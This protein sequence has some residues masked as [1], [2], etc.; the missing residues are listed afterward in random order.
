MSDYKNVYLQLSYVHR[1]DDRRET[2]SKKFGAFEKKQLGEVEIKHALTLRAPEGM[3]KREVATLVSYYLERYVSI[4]MKSC[5]IEQRHVSDAVANDIFNIQFVNDGI[6][7]EMKKDFCF[8]NDH[9]ITEEEKQ[10]L[11]VLKICDT[12]DKGLAKSEAAKNF[13]QWKEL[14]KNEAEVSKIFKKYYKDSDEN[15]AD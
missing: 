7:Q 13:A 12:F 11:L 6:N 15:V 8:V 4:Q 14:Y 5:R 9:P 3:T 1:E 10:G 2:Y